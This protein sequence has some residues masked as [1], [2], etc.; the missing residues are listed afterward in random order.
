MK[1]T[2]LLTISL[3]ALL[4]TSAMAVE[5]DMDYSG[6][7]DSYTGLPTYEND[8]V[9]NADQVYL[10]SNAYYDRTD[11]MYVHVLDNSKMEIRCSV[12][13]GMVTTDSV[14]FAFAEGLDG[15]LYCDG[16]EVDITDISEVSEPGSYVL[17]VTT[18]GVTVQPFKFTIVNRV[19]GALNEYRLLGNFAVT[20]VLLD[21]NAV[22][23]NTN[24]VDLS[25]EG[26]YQITY[27]CQPTGVRYD[28]N[29]IVDHTAPT[30]A[31]EAVE[32]GVARGP[33]DISDAE[34]GADV[35]I[36]LD[37]KKQDRTAELTKS[38]SYSVTIT[39][40]AGNSNNYKFVIQVYFNA[41]SLV[42]FALTLAVLIALICY[43]VGS[44]RRL[45]VR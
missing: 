43:L 32:D 5:I 20:E 14:S 27:Y 42:F 23:F 16:D 34:E 25:Q 17:S 4:T 11:G 9:V 21:G 26:E 19:T 13:T 6:V 36:E 39:D 30:L 1:K 28:L 12:A 41:N 15:E 38:G 40:E 35:Y 3:L 31:L 10:S 37:G 2:L 29:I 24:A 45:R 33:V 44:R 8:V 22:E 18:G 7:V